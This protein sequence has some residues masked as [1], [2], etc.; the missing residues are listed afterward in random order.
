MLFSLKTDL[1]KLEN[2]KDRMFNVLVGLR[3]FFVRWLIPLFKTVNMGWLWN[4]FDILANGHVGKH[5]FNIWTC[6]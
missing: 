3:R 4:V 5:V 1:K 2:I 6:L